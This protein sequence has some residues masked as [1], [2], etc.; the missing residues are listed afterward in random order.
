MRLRATTT[1]ILPPLYGPPFPGV[2]HREVKR[3]KCQVRVLLIIRLPA[4]IWRGHKPDWV[5]SSVMHTL[6]PLNLLLHAATVLILP[7]RTYHFLLHLTTLFRDCTTTRKFISVYKNHQQ[8]VWMMYGCCLTPDISMEEN[9]DAFKR[10]LKNF[11][12]L[13]VF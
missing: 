4:L 2:K 7:P 11:L 1:S 3:M 6:G 5:V 12:F 8:N 9:L 13:K 10:M